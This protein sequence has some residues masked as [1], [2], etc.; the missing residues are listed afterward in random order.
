MFPVIRIGP[1]AIQAP[2]LILLVGLWFG[3]NLAERNARLRNVNPNLLYNLV[4]VILIS[5]LIGGRLGYAALYFQ[6]FLASPGSLFSLNPGLFDVWSGL[7]TGIVAGVVYIQKKKL[8]FWDVCD[9]LTPALGLLQIANALANLA[10][11]NGFGLPSNLP[12]A[13][14]LWGAARHPTQ[15]YEI[16][17]GVGILW[18][19][20]P[21]KRLGHGSPSGT[22]ILMFFAFSAGA[23]LI[24]EA[25]RSTSYL[26]PGGFRGE[27]LLAW[28][29]LGLCLLG[30]D[31]RWT[32]EGKPHPNMDDN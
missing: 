1:L 22:T 2:G 20:W 9:A 17:A 31:R 14:Q 28:V 21:G 3:L 29:I 8:P 23:R 5:G 10:S 11:G 15:A 19:F 25:F 24:L 32:A 30:L 12:W 27:Q 18:L 7:A 16:L 6:A 26:L 13:I 4:F